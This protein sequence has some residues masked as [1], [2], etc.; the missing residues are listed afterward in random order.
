MKAEDF[1]L[2]EKDIGDDYEDYWFK[3][4]GDTKK[5]LESKYMEQSMIGVTKCVY[6][7]FEDIVGVEKLFP[8]NNYITIP[9]DDELKQ[10]LR[11]LAQ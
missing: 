2:D 9:N 8:F 10:I 1:V 11:E 3:V 4:L 5:E 7:K 6:S